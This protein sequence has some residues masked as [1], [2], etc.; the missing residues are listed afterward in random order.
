MGAAQLFLKLQVVVQLWANVTYELQETHDDLLFVG[1]HTALHL[2]K[3]MLSFTADL[4]LDVFFS[5]QVLLFVLF[6]STF[7]FLKCKI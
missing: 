5:A 6:E 3:L 2:G 7:F 4:L 1:S